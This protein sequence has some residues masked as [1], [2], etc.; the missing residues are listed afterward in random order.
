ML[1][2]DKLLRTNELNF[3]MLAL[4]PAVV[5]VYFIYQFVTR[6]RSNTKV[7]GGIRDSLRQVHFLL[8]KNNTDDNDVLSPREYGRLII[9]LNKLREYS[10][11]LN[12]VQKA[13]IIEDLQEVETE[14]YSVHQRLVTVDRM[15]RTYK[16]LAI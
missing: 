3:T 12:R 7:E 11:N 10:Q 14:K 1:Q 16:F 5:V 4:L 2:L 8:N 9:C 6:E 13:W 15:Y